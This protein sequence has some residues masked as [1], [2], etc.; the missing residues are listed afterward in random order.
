MEYEM[1][2]RDLINGHCAYCRLYNQE[3]TIA[4]LAACDECHSYLRRGL[5]RADITLKYRRDGK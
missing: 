4:E 2:E 3:I 5:E 1:S